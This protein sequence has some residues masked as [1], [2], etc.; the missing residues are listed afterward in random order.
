M[1][2][3][4]IEQGDLLSDKRF[5]RKIAERHDATAEQLAL[6]W[7]L[8]QTGVIAIPEGKLRPLHVRQNRASRWTSGN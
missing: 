8:R 2:Y 4:P 3:S 5:A 7:V 1:V 6:A